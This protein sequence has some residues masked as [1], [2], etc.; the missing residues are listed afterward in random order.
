MC[1]Y[2]AAVLGAVSAHAM[3]QY[4]VFSSRRKDL[5]Y[6]SFDEYYKAYWMAQNFVLYKDRPWTMKNHIAA[7]I[8]FIFKV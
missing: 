1:F 3:H 2:E 4:K 7:A 6:V 8:K 5:R